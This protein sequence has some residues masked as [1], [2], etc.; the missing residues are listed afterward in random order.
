MYSIFMS[1]VADPRSDERSD[2]SSVAP[3]TIQN[4]SSDSEGTEKET[5]LSQCDQGPKVSIGSASFHVEDICPTLCQVCLQKPP[6]II[7]QVSHPG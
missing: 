4:S 1:F 2:H 6:T 7:L 5:M 3:I